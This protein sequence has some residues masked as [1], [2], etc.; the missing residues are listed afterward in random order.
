MDILIATRKGLMV[1]EDTEQ[2]LSLTGRHFLG[3]PVSNVV[4][5]AAG[6][7]YAALNLGHFGPKMH[8]SVDRGAHWTEI[9]CPTLPE[10]PPSSSDSTDWTVKQVWELTAFA[11]EPGHLL[12]GTNPGAVF[13]TTDGGQSWQLNDAFWQLEQRPG[14]FGGGFD[15]SG[16][17]SISI[18]SD[19][20]SSWSVAVSVGGVWHTDNAGQSWAL[21]CAGMVA[22]YM[23]EDMVDSEDLQDPHRM[24]RCLS[25]PDRCWVQ[26]HCGIFVSDDGGHQWRECQIDGRSSFGF[27]VVVHPTSPDTA[28]F[29]PGIK[30]ESRYPKDGQLCVLR[31][32]DGGQTFERLRSGLPQE[33][34]YDLIYRHALAISQDGQRLVMGS[35]TGNVWVSDDQGEHWHCLS[36]HLPPVYAVVIHSVS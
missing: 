34:C 3:D 5:D 11:D 17:H 36:N 14:W 28:W 4:V 12:A 8:K 26:H 33:D 24:V 29:V 27:S 7:W 13:E 16:V 25:A 31:T 20:P 6:V 19:D 32:Q 9:A 22:D 23:P 2:G 18:R 15:D 30:D 21:H 35:T 10:K 1:Y